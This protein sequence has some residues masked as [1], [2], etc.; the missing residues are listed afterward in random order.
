MNNSKKKIAL[1]IPSMYPS[2]GAE[3]V[4][5]RLASDLSDTYDVTVITLAENSF[6]DTTYQ[7]ATLGFSHSKLSKI[8]SLLWGPYALL[9]YCKTNEI[10]LVV[11]HMERANFIALLSKVPT[12]GVV[13]N[14]KYLTTPFNKFF[15]SQL[16]PRAK[17]II[18]VSQGVETK[19]QELFSLTN[20]KTIYNYFDLETIDNKLQE[21]LSEKDAELFPDGIHTVITIGRLVEQK[22][23]DILIRSFAH[24]NLKNTQLIIIGEG[25]KREELILLSKTLGIEKKVHLI[26]TR[27]NVFPLLKASDCFVLSSRWEGFGLVLVEA[28]AAG[29]PIVSTDCLSGPREILH[30]R[31]D[32]YGALAPVDDH[33]KFAQEIKKVMYQ[34][35]D[36]PHQT[37]RVKI[38]SKK[39]VL[40]EWISLLKS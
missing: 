2:G 21:P 38:F 13:H 9:K 23:Q 1:F 22:G 28:L 26:G 3:R 36:A 33:K 12:V 19:L 29:L 7:Q 5:H 4:T 31:D 14:Y 16:Y 27:E 37:S 35:T 32:V 30:D 17:K 18:A 25:G 34:P 11:S 24:A 15:I 20:T 8:W 10:E 6:K 39:E 40:P